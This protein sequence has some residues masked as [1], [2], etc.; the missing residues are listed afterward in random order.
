MKQTKQKLYGAMRWAITLA[1]A[2]PMMA[3]A[4]NVPAEVADNGYADSIYFNGRIVSMEDRK[5]TR[6]NSS[7]T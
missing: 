6:L 5:S 1:L 3:R 7:H 2:L 4:Q